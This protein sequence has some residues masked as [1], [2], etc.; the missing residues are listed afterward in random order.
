MAESDIPGVSVA[1]VR[2]HKVVWAD[3]FGVVSRL[4][5]RAISP[6]S[7]FEA[8]SISKVITAYTAL[9]LVEEG[10]LSLERPVH[11]QLTKPWL[12][13]S[14]LSDKITLR[15]LLSHSSGL[16]DDPFFK[17]KR[18]AFEPGSRFRYSGTGA[19]Y[20]R[21]L[22]E[23]ATGDSLES[24]AKELVFGPL[25]MTGSSFANEP[26]VMAHMANG[27]MRCIALVTPFIVVSLLV[28]LIVLVLNRAVTGGWRMSRKSIVVA[29]A[30]SFAVAESL[31][32]IVLGEAFPNLVWLS[33]GC[34]LVFIGTMGLSY[35]LIRFILCRAPGLNQRSALRFGVVLV[36][37]LTSVALVAK[38]GASV[39]MPVPRNHSSE[40]S[41]I[42]SLRATATDLAAFLIELSDPR[43]VSESVASQI[44]ST[45]TPISNDFSWGL[46][47]GIQHSEYGDAIWQN[48]ITL[49]FRG[50]MVIYPGEGH[51]AVV[52][53]NSES[54]LHAAYDIAAR[55]LGGKAQWEHF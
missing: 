41:A 26:H 42:G 11:L 3:G 33:I 54:G 24:V 36:W 19:E 25:D 30:S 21:E 38:V 1:L 2:D 8:A 13:S 34:V 12:P 17:S 31:F 40:I 43:Y 16:G 28:W 45:Q 6:K 5:G 23:Q 44:R 27:H 32:C 50:I 4:T 14:A 51:G 53:T 20:V 47:I 52:L 39:S 46:G 22:I 35:A 48:G 15:H 7:T 18:I 10:K 49:A 55:A 37:M 9:R 29:V